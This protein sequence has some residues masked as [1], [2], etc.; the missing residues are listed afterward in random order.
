MRK[1]ILSLFRN[2]LDRAS[3][4]VN[5]TQRYFEI[6]CTHISIYP[7]IVNDLVPYPLHEFLGTVPFRVQLSDLGYLCCYSSHSYL[8]LLGFM[9][10]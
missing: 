3:I 5:E 9:F 8:R 6:A 4:K 7:C 10:E 1:V 2:S